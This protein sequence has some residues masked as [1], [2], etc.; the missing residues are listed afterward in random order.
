MNYQWLRFEIDDSEGGKEIYNCT[1]TFDG[2]VIGHV[3]YSLNS[4]QYSFFPAY[5]NHILTPHIMRDI[6]HFLNQLQRHKEIDKI[7][8]RTEA[9]EIKTK[10]VIFYGGSLHGTSKRVNIFNVHWFYNAVYP[11]FN[12]GLYEEGFPQEPEFIGKEIYKLKEVRFPKS[13]ISI[14]RFVFQSKE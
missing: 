8:W 14:Y 5:G 7:K 3:E 1:N 13:K 9:P 2:K 12:P 6:L 11:E 10:L 4:K